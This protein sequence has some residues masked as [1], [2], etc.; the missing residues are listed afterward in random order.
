MHGTKLYHDN[1]L[2]GRKM[3]VK[4]TAMFVH[5]VSDNA[6]NCNQNCYS[7]TRYNQHRNE[8]TVMKS[9]SNLTALCTYRT[10]NL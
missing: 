1:V 4:L 10:D 5:P 9:H 3:N 6:P 8:H 2:D 7:Q